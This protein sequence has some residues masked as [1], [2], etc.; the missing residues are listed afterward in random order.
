MNEVYLL[1]KHTSFRN[2]SLLNQNELQKKSI[3]ALEGYMEG[4]YMDAGIIPMAY[5]YKNKVK[6]NKFFKGSDVDLVKFN[7]ST[8]DALS[9]IFAIFPATEVVRINI[10][11]QDLLKELVDDKDFYIVMEEWV[12]KGRSVSLV[13]DGTLAAPSHLFPI[14]SF[15]GKGIIAQDNGVYQGTVDFRC[16]ISK[17]P[18]KVIKELYMKRYNTCL[19]CPH[20][21]M[22]EELPRCELCTC[23]MM[24]KAEQ[25]GAKCA[26][27]SDPKW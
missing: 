4:P 24:V 18:G 27:E 20:M 11:G 5:L 23:N 1:S 19:S 21:K 12:T 17:K 13:F 9:K 25:L 2:L 14:W 26:D 6:A 8:K 15:P 16:D 7:G 3:V 10:L 22:I